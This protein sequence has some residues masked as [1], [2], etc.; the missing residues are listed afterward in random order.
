M[1]AL[2]EIDA[3][4]ADADAEIDATATI[5][6]AALEEPKLRRRLQIN[7]KHVL[8]GQRSSLDYLAVEMTRRFGTENSTKAYYPLATTPGRFAQSIEQKMP[9]VAESRPDV[10]AAV[11][12]HQPFGV[13]E[14]G[15]LVALVNE[16]KHNRLNVQLLRQVHQ[17]DVTEI[18]TGTT[19]RWRGLTFSRSED[20]IDTL[21]ES[22]GGFIN[23]FERPG[24]ERTALDQRDPEEVF[25]IAG[26]PSV[27]GVPIDHETQ[28][29]FPAPH[30]SAKRSPVDEWW[31]LEP[32]LSVYPTLLGVQ[33]A[34]RRAV[35]EV[36]VAA[37]L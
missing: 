23:V 8:E 36:A 30:I 11:R 20:G 25:D 12:R 18:A 28:L 10:A 15:T 3:L 17:S 7:V 32:H 14:L 4:L 6:D 9:G 37:D 35:A 33:R 16:A 19:V 22:T 1:T 13:P 34:V 2:D 5:H 27:F 29:P 26:G 24:A 21:I 31:F